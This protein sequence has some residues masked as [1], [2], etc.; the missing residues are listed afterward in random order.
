LKGQTPPPLSAGESKAQEL[1]PLHQA[2]QS[3]YICIMK[4]YSTNY[5]V[6]TKWLNNSFIMCNHIGEID[7]EIYDNIRF[8]LEDEETGEY[9]DIYQWFITDCSE[10]DVAFLEKHFNLLFTYSPLLDCYI[11]AVDHC[12]T[13]WDYVYCDTDLEQAARELGAEK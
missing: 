8:S 11:L 6:A 9:R 12:G 5:R 3:K 4:K 2:R 10:F 1:P 7:P 13:S